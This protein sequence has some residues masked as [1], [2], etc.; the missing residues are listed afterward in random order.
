MT[1]KRPLEPND[2]YHLRLISDPQISPDGG[3]IAFVLRRLDEKDDESKSNIYVVDPDGAVTRFTSGEKDSAPRWSPDGKHLAFLSGRKDKTQIYVIP[4]RGGEAIAVTD[5]KLGAGAPVWS[6]DSTAIAFAAMVSTLPDDEGED[7]DEKKKEPT[8]IFERSFYKLDTEGYIWHRRSHL[9]RVD[10]AGL[11]VT[12][13]TE[14][15]Q[16]DSEPQWSPDGSLLT[17]VSNRSDYWDLVEGGDVYTMP[18]GGG[19][20]RQVTS[21]GSFMAPVFSPDGERIAMAGFESADNTYVPARLFSIGVD[22]EGLRDEQGSWEGSIGNDVAGDVSRP[23]HALDLTWRGDGIYFVGTVHGEA[24]IY[25]AADGSVDAVTTGR[26]SV[27]DYSIADDG[28]I[29]FTCTDSTHLAQI[30]LLT[31][32]DTRQLTHEGE[33]FLAEVYIGQPER[34]TFTGANGEESDGWLLPPRGYES[35]KHPLLVYIHGGPA[36]AHGEAF[37]FEYQLLAGQGFGVFYPNIHGSS[38]YGQAYQESIRSDWG[39][40]DYQDVLAGTEAAASRPWVDR[41]RVGIAGGSY[42]GYMVNWVMTHSDRFKAGLTERCLSNMISFIGSSDAGWWWK[43]VWGVYPEED[44]QRLWDM[45]PLKYVT[46]VRSPL[47]VMHSDRD[48]RCPVEQA[49]QMFNALRRLRKETKMI[50]FP[51]E[52]HELSRSGTPSRRVERL[53]HITDWFRQ[54]L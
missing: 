11:E 51:E 18:S 50:I 28:A 43:Q 34:F 38:S 19:D 33:D 45:S 6:P 52:S 47:L 14:G 16:H 3:R 41:D 21:G 36:T 27:N 49:E 46:N 15:D 12:Q 23:S 8:R 39:N 5:L 31:H 1:D 40:L 13:L 29:A 48:D 4:S 10:V 17:F 37:F 25:R 30:Y 24:N 22:G 44:A 2:L 35:G 9:F 26:H 53:G 32:G 20:A 7:K 54:H 42:G